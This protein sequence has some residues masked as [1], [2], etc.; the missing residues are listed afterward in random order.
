M[1]YDDSSSLE[2]SARDLRMSKVDFEKRW[3]HVPIS[4]GGPF[5]DFLGLYCFIICLGETNI[6]QG[7]FQTEGLVL[8]LTRDPGLWEGWC[9]VPK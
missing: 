6:S 1:N 7:L 5:I 4:N 9:V 2:V 8:L 3:S